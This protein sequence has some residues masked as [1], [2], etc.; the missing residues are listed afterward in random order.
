M[1]QA[2]AGHG[3]AVASMLRQACTR[4]ALPWTRRAPQGR[5]RLCTMALARSLR[6]PVGALFGAERACATA[7]AGTC[8]RAAGERRRG[9]ATSS[10]SGGGGEVTLFEADGTQSE[11]FAQDLVA[12][13]RFVLVRTTAACPAAP[14]PRCWRRVGL[15]LGLP[16]PP[17]PPPQL[18]AA[19][20]LP[21]GGSLYVVSGSTLVGQPHALSRPRP[22]LPWRDLA[23]RN[24]TPV[25]S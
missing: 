6:S 10:S 17:P 21:L 2:Q 20:T 24:G 1:L 5:A 7:C 19:Q 15:T 4:R 18:A 11:A 3:A 8:T 23:S 12:V 9:L 22:Y 13:R 25:R 16:R 14:R